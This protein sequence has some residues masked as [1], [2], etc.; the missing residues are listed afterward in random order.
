MTTRKTANSFTKPDVVVAVARMLLTREVGQRI[1]TLAELQAR[2]GAGT[3]TVVKALRA[4]EDDGAVRL[5]P[6]GRHGTVV[7]G[8]DVGR[9]WN[10]ADL[11]NF[12]LVM[13]PPGPIEQQGT[14]EVVQDTLRRLGVALVVDF[15]RGAES[16][17]TEVHQ[18]RAHAT[19]TSAGALEHHRETLPGLLGADLGP[20]TFY[21]PG[22]LVV[23]EHRD[24]PPRDPL[25]VGIDRS[26]YDHERL[27][28][29]AFA[30]RLVRF[31]DCSFVRAPAAVLA[32]DI[33]T[34]IWHAMPTV[35]PPELAGLTLR[36]LDPGGGQEGS[37]SICRAVLVTRAND[38][39]TNAL[40][41]AVR[42]AAIT[43]RQNEL[44]QAAD[45]EPGHLWPR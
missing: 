14:L 44:L 1:P 7:V 36:P 4:M 27:S 30:G 25:V 39:C 31:A 26:S 12:R 43:R 37:E 17:L 24:R 42:P 10:A 8:R 41:R 45:D 21:S 13:P 40:L 11:G 38:A 3:G 16:R 19:L 29:Q 33:D 35:I 20:N 32:G 5:E 22:S 18:E 34:A 2:A 15:L 9:L 23:V 28:R 6:R